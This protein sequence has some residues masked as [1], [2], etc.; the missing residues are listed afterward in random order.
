MEGDPASVTFHDFEHH[1]AVVTFRGGV[2]AI[3]R[4]GCAAHGG[5]KSEC[6]K[7]S[8][9]VV[10]NGFGNTDDRNPVFE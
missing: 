1:D 3:E 9:K 5:I 4:I 7:R 8:F 2:Q 10:I 6:E